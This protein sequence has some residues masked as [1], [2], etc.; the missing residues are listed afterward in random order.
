MTIVFL[1]VWGIKVWPTSSWTGKKLSSIYFFLTSSI[2][3]ETHH[4]LVCENFWNTYTRPCQTS[5][6]CPERRKSSKKKKIPWQFSLPLSSSFEINHKRSTIGK[7]KKKNVNF[8]LWNQ[9]WEKRWAY[10]FLSCDLEP[11]WHVLCYKMMI[12]IISWSICLEISFSSP[13]TRDQGFPNS[14]NNL[15]Y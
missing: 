2:K 5:S 6:G 8:E 13:V 15:I 3:S 14:S 12:D 1:L 7:K 11:V 9:T 4:H 10:A